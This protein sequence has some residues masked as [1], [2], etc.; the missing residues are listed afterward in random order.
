[1]RSI[2]S[3]LFVLLAGLTA[4]NFAPDNPQAFDDDDDSVGGD[5]DDSVSTDPVAATISQLTAGDFAPETLVTV[6]GV[7]TTPVWTDEDPEE[8]DAYFWI[9]DGSGPGTGIVIYT[10]R[11][12]VEEL[13]GQIPPGAE[14]RITG[15]YAIP[16]DFPQIRLSQ[17]DNLEVTG[18]SQLP[19]AHPITP[20][21][22]ASGQADAELIGILVTMEGALVTEGP[23]YATYYE[24]EVGGAIV[25]DF[26]Y[27]ADVQAN[28]LMTRLSGVVHMSYGDAKLFPRW[29][30]DVVYTYP[31]CDTA[32]TGSDN[33][34]A[35]NCRSTPVESPAS[36][37][38]L[39]V[40]SPETWYGDAFYAVDPNVSAF[41][42][43][44]IYSE[45]DDTTIPAL[46]SIV[47]INNAEFNEYRGNSQLVIAGDTAVSNTGT[48]S[49]IASLAVSVTDPCSISEAH[50]GMLVTIPSVTVL[51]QDSN[52][53]SWG[54][55]QVSGCSE[56]RVGS[57]LFTDAEAFNS[58]S[59]GAGTITNLTGVISA[60]Y[61]VWTIN[62]RDNNDWSSWAGN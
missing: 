41:G 40:V 56:V 26:F 18:S 42:G 49:D 12:V 6:S 33:L 57:E 32:W 5:D 44:L 34:Q 31:G 37:S 13:A 58:A 52:C 7:V 62:P 4:C 17:V 22:I 1:M 43:I 16:F 45:S 20:D 30:D 53:S 19:A 55:Y 14:V 9:Q 25:D 38:G 48:H 51:A 24:W 8:A 3:L 60:R 28:Y 11:D 29:A 47:D 27:Y 50:E 35:L 23:S 2:H 39:V 21:D 54:Y 10:F 46:G 36:A 61:N 15:N 59:G